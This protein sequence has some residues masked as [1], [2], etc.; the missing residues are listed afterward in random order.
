MK[1][2][3]NFFENFELIFF[4]LICFLHLL[5]TYPIN[6]SFFIFIKFIDF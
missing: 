4:I 1:D 3:E 5:E 6:L 2:Q